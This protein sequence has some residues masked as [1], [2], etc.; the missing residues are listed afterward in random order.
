MEHGWNRSCFTIESV[1]HCWMILRPLTSP[2]SFCSS[3][4]WR[5]C[6]ERIRRASLLPWRSRPLW[7]NEILFCFL[8]LQF[9]PC[10]K[11]YRMSLLTRSRSFSN[12]RR[13]SLFSVVRFTRWTYNFSFGWLSTRAKWQ[14]FNRNANEIDDINA[15]N[16]IN[17]M[18]NPAS[19]AWSFLAKISTF[20]SLRGEIKTWRHFVATLAI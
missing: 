18:E 15:R 3:L 8:Q 6:W 11:R 4:V 20:A 13:F 1:L 5:S 14:E 16:S 9:C 12:C 10:F 19:L 2:N 17:A 7:V